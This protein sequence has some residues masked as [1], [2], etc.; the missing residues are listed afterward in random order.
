[1]DQLA[2]GIKVEHEHGELYDAMA[3][4]LKPRKMP[5]S[6]EDFFEGIAKAH[7]KELPDYYS[8]LEKMEGK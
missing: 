2:Q 7:I 4:A 3:R 8:R 6:R 1:M 5:I